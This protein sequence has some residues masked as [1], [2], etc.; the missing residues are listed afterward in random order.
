MLLPPPK[1]PLKCVQ[2]YGS[3]TSTATFGEDGIAWFYKSCLNPCPLMV[4]VIKKSGAV[5]L[6]IGTAPFFGH[7][8]GVSHSWRLFYLFYFPTP[9]IVC[10]CHRVLHAWLSF[11]PYTSIRHAQPG[12]RSLADHPYFVNNPI[13]YRLESIDPLIFYFA[14]ISA[15][16]VVRRIV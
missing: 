14:C 10:L 13:I 5:P 16:G 9:P 4:M 8:P 3:T 15:V 2:F 7:F 1:N 12:T 11:C 6:M